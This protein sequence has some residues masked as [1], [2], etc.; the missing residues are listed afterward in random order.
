MLFS[1]ILIAAMLPLF[2][3]GDYYRVLLLAPIIALINIIL[4]ASISS[5]LAEFVPTDLR[6]R[7][8]GSSGFI[9]LLV[10]SLGQIIGGYLYD[11]VSHTLSIYLFCASIVPVFL[12]TLLFI[13]NPEN[14]QIKSQE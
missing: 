11:N 12:L 8:S 14:K 9:L 7:I 3:G 13:K 5:L 2:I 10:G 6:G 4:G 1:F